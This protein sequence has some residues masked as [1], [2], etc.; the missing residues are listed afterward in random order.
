MSLRLLLLYPFKIVDFNRRLIIQEEKKR[1]FLSLYKSFIYKS[2][3][4]KQKEEVSVKIDY[5][6]RRGQK[7][8]L[9]DYYRF[10][11]LP[12]RTLLYKST[13]LK[14]GEGSYS[15]FPMRS[16]KAFTKEGC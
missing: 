9:F 13:I 4:G 2:I 14:E 10:V 11:F 1:G 6:K 12:M 15:C 8:P 3:I 7:V 5:F 16:R